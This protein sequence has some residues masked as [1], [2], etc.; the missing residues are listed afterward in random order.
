M[1]YNSVPFSP[2]TTYTFEPELHGPAP[3]RISEELRQG[4]HARRQRNAILALLGSGALCWVISY[5]TAIRDVGQYLLP[6]AYLDWIGLGLLALG[7]GAFLLKTVMPGPLR[8][9]ESGIPTVALIRSIVKEPARIVNGQV[10]DLRFRVLTELVLP[11]SNQPI[12]REILSPTFSV[13][14]KDRVTTS[15]AVGDYVTAVF[16]PRDP[17]GTLRLYGFLNLRSGLGLVDRRKTA[18]QRSWPAKVALEILGGVVVFAILFWNVY[19]FSQFEPLEPSYREA[20]WFMVLGGIV[21]GGGFL[22]ATYLGHRTELRQIEDRNREAAVRGEAL[23]TEASSFWAR[24][25]LYGFGFKVLIFVGGLLLGAVTGLC[26][27]YSLNSLLDESEPRLQPVEVHQAYTETTNFVLRRY[28]VK[29]RL[30]GDEEDRELST[31][32]DNVRAL[33]GSSGIATIRAGWLGWPW[34]EGIRPL[35]EG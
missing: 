28:L 15:F 29:Y 18:S 31:T 12:L 6:L 10:A 8:Y 24:S 13:I 3:R 30:P 17:A 35:D 16:L 5:P 2:P 4:P 32:P 14:R 20:T 34:I 25:G 22:L 21:L 33:L 23:E 26:W 27:A 11:G 7:A 1:D 9:V 19:A